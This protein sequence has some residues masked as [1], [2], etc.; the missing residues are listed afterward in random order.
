MKRKWLAIP[1]VTGLLAAGLTGASVLAH[2]E[3]G[4]DQTPRETVAAKVAE[5]L[6]IEDEQTV[7][8]ALQLATQEVQQD[9]LQHRL[10][11]MVEAGTLTQEQADEYLS[12]YEARPEG[13]NLHRNGQ[14]S[15]RFGGGEGEDGR[16]QSGFRGQRFGGEDHPGFGQRPDGGQGADARQLPNG[17]EFPGQGEV[18]S[19]FSQRFGGQQ[20]PGQG[21]FA[22]GFGGEAPSQVPSEAPGGVP[23]GSSTSY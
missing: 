17:R 14:R 4:E 5:I 1:I 11:D 10:D 19:R 7:K 23:E 22:P 21:Q 16:P 20:F 8:D 2:N 13:P 12:W 18:R 9:R 3:D 15:F 6:G